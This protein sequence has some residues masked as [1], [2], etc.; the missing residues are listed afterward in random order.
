[1]ARAHYLELL[2]YKTYADLRAEAARTYISFLWWI[3][4]PLIFMA[5]FYVVFGL[6]FQRYDE[7]FVPSLLIG[8]VTWRWFDNTVRTGANAIVANHGLMQQVY[9]PKHLF[10]SVAV[11]VS[12]AKFLLVFVLLLALLQYLA[13]GIS[14][15]YLWLPVPLLVEF[16][17]VSGT[18]MLVAALVPFFPDLRIII[19]NALLLLFFLS[20]VFFSVDKIPEQ[21][22]QYLFLNPMA[23]LIDAYRNILISSRSPP[24]GRMAIIALLSVIL[25]VTARWLLR[26]YDRRYARRVLT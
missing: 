3:I 26:R 10:P 14:M 6:V 2:L 12:T 9:L 25:I 19:G 4:E 15:A 11:L 13:P 24:L 22:R 7:E 16:L 8:L 1:M 17:L 20:G 18:A 21:Y 23:G 5:V